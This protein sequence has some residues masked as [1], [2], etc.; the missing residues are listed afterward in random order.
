MG[1]TEALEAQWNMYKQLR[2]TMDSWMANDTLVFAG[3][4]IVVYGALEL[5]FNGLPR[6]IE[7]ARDSVLRFLVGM[8]EWIARSLTAA[9]Y[10]LM[11]FAYDTTIQILLRIVGIPV[12]E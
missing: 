1:S 9:A 5:A 12:E 2:E 8:S 6:N 3:H 11:F 10:E 7:Q 4:F